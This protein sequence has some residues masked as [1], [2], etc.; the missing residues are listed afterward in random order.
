MEMGIHGC[1]KQKRVYHTCD[2]VGLFVATLLVAFHAMGM[3]A[4]VSP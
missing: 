4:M 2:G 3:H 1:D